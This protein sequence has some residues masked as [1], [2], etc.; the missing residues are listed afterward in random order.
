MIKAINHIGIAVKDLDAS[1]E[2]FKKIFNFESIHKEVVADQKVAVGSFKVGDVLIELTSP[3]A[4]D[5]PIAKF[6]EKRGEGIHHIAF[7]TDNVSNELSRLSEEGIQLIDKAPRPG[8]HDMLISF[9]HPKST[10]G[11]LMELCQHQE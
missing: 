10:N 7:E 6:I 8:A 1:I 3:T 11:V 4:D 2:L 5:S 9:L